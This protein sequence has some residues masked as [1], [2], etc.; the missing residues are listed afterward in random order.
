MPSFGQK[1]EGRWP[2]HAT[3]ASGLTDSVSLSATETRA[4][5]LAV[6]MTTH[7]EPDRSGPAAVEPLNR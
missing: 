4:V 3:T 1:P 2:V 7:A 5:R 6:A